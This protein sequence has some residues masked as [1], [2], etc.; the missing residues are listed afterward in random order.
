[1]RVV[2]KIL[3]GLLVVVL[4][5]ALVGGAFFLWSVRRSFPQTS[6]TLQI[7]GLKGEV[8]VIRNERGIPDIYADTPEDLF[9]AMG[10]VVA[11]DR[12]WQM[13]FNRHV[14]SGRLSE[15]FGQSTVDQDA[16]LRTMGWHDIA[17]KEYQMLAPETRTNLT[18]YAQGI[19]DYLEG[20]SAAEVSFEYVVLGLQNPNYQIEKWD[21]VDS[22]AWLKAMAF[23]LMANSD[24]EISRVLT[25]A[26]VGV[27]RAEELFPP[28]P[29]ERNGTI[30]SNAQDKNLAGSEKD[31]AAA[32]AAAVVG[33]R[34]ARGAFERTLAAQES[35]SSLIKREGTAGDGIG[36]DSWVVSGHLTESGKP[37]LANDMHLGPQMPSIWYQAGLHCRKVSLA[38]PYDVA[39]FV[40][41]NVPGVIVGHNADVAWGFTNLGPDVSDLVLE[42]V[43]GDSY[44]I[45]GRKQPIRTRTET[46]KVAGGDPIELKVRSTAAGPIVSDIYGDSSE[47]FV[48]VGKEA[49]VPAPGQTIKAPP[50]KKG[51]GY[52]VAIQWTALTPRPTM[53]AVPVIDTA[54]NFKQFRTA[55]ELFTVPAQNM[56][57]ADTGGQVAYQTPGVIPVRRGY[58]GHWPVP[59]WDSQF[60]WSG[61][62]PFDRLPSIKDPPAGWITTANQYV[63][64]ADSPQADVQTD[65]Y[66]YGARAKRIDTDLASIVNSGQKITIPD[67]QH[68]QMDA[69]NDLAAW[70]VPRLRQFTPDSDAQQA[71]Q[72][73]NGWDYQ[74]PSTS[75]A[76]MYFNAFY[77]ALLD[78]MLTD[79][80]GSQKAVGFNAGDRFWEVIRVLWGKPNNAWWD[81]AATPQKEDRDQTVTNALNAAAAQ[82][83]T[84]QGSDPAKWTWGSLHTLTLENLSLGRSGVKPV[85][86]IFNRGPVETSGG[87][88]IPLA[89]NWL[90]ADGYDVTAVPSMRQVV[91]LSDPD[92][93]TWVNL[94]GNS[95]HTYNANYVDQ[96]DA[97]NTGTQ[98]PWAFTR[99]AVNSA[100]ANT[101]TLQP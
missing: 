48:D 14:T 96:L 71:M 39:G 8:Q 81:D 78:R 51:A 99:E 40:L 64:P 65:V 46:L 4:V 11:Q 31:A 68:T 43:H 63:V 73:F 84:D 52:A 50:A 25:A 101:L 7:E 27:P 2:G 91:D 16:F 54:K 47:P 30:V 86:M 42:Q 45:D 33:S 89:T 79:E 58:N 28:Y 38:C 75:A 61:Y 53:D 18:S 29:Y 10:Y 59:G 36:S 56:I 87:G 70:L 44:I 80:L 37:L 17:Q 82:M 3:L 5:L 74:Q 9:M 15:M 41:P 90:P 24:Q 77:K 93:S 23:D 98:Y 100:G 22:V 66:S 49:P 13:D 62:I 72:L 19:N 34:S 85:E 32:T 21:P 67:M 20:K 97:W 94:T 26:K 35:V 12:F 88:S 83:A 69:G 92:N 55:A 6:G 60:K 95:G 57:Y 76:A 1:M